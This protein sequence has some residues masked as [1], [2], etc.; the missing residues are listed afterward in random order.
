MKKRLSI[1]FT[2]VTSLCI[3]VSPVH[4][5]G[6]N[7]KNFSVKAKSTQIT[8]KWKKVKNATS[9]QIG[10]RRGQTW[11]SVWVSKKATSR[12]LTMAREKTK[13]QLRMRAFKKK[14]AGP[15][16]KVKTVKTGSY[17]QKISGLKAKAYT[18]SLKLSWK[19]VVNASKLE[20]SYKRPTAR[21]YAK[22]I[23]SK[24]TSYTLTSLRSN[25]RYYVKMRPIY[26]NGKYGPYTKR[27]TYQTKAASNKARN[28]KV[29]ASQAGTVSLADVANVTATPTQNA[30]MKVSWTQNDGRNGYY[31]KYRK[32]GSNS[33]WYQ[34]KASGE[35]PTETTISSLD[36]A[37]AY[38]FSV[39]R[40]SYD[41]KSYSAWSPVITATTYKLLD[42]INMDTVHVN[43]TR[44]MVITWNP[45]TNSDRYQLVIK[46]GDKTILNQA[47]T[48]ETY[49]YNNL[50]FETQY[51]VKVRALSDTYGQDDFQKKTFTT[52]P[53]TQMNDLMA[54]FF[55]EHFT[56]A[57]QAPFNDATVGTL[58]TSNQYI[59][60]VVA[61]ALKDHQCSSTDTRSL[62]NDGN[63][64]TFKLKGD[65][66]QDPDIYN[67]MKQTE[68]EQFVKNT[69]ASV[70]KENG[71]VQPT[72]DE[73]VFYNDNDYKK[74][75]EQIISQIDALKSDPEFQATLADELTD[76][77]FV[78]SI[79]VM[80][81][82]NTLRTQQLP[83]LSTSYEMM[84]SSLM[85][86]NGIASKSFS[87]NLTH[88]AYI[89]QMDESKQCIARNTDDP[90][91][92]WQN[93]VDSIDASKKLIDRTLDAQLKMMSVAYSSHNK[94]TVFDGTTDAVASSLKGTAVN[95]TDFEQAFNNYVQAHQAEFIQN[96]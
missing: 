19:S 53:K 67:L 89:H 3:G 33:T 29:K 14:V 70:L 32:A 92:V 51:Q 37:T 36:P 90:V 1:V 38:E 17:Y 12:T 83:E 65:T 25:S 9:Y 72:Y 66:N 13:Y 28:T 52:M 59:E 15:W 96:V 11:Y 47:V 69:Y 64:F 42:P 8:A 54:G 16:T 44:S 6:P 34:I 93:T 82:V 73:S 78:K 80:K 49:T 21:R 22:V 4:A 81:K 30:T 7:V 56:T 94:M 2:M 91:T 68:I 76:Q 85:N 18:Y 74:Q 10:Y 35:N 46:A 20:I 39:K 57:V 63:Y 86:L 88:V 24:R 43:G 61:Y 23:I 79:D 87:T 62:Y 5:K 60:K 31:V 77:S 75:I 41:A 58:D 50:D 45:V 84:V 40:Y 27:M 95:V 55:N 48:G 26:R 71:G